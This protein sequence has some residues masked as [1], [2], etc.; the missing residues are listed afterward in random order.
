MIRIDGQQLST[1]Q[2]AAAVAGP[3]SVEVS[4]QA[5]DRVAR[6]H[7]QAVLAGRLR[8]IY[9]LTTG[10]GANR[11][12]DVE[13]DTAGAQ[14]L[15]RSHATAA[16]M[17]RSAER[18]RAMLLIRLN[19]LCAGGAGL[20][21]AVVR[22]LAD[23]VNADEL[24]VIREFVGI[25]TAELSALAATALALQ[26]RSPGLVFGPHDAL[27]FISSNAA[28]LSDAALAATRLVT[29]ARAALA[30]AALSFAAVRGNAEA[31]AAPVEQATPMPGART[32]CRVMRGLVG[33][34]EPA[35][36]QDPYGLRALPQG[37][38]MLLDA[39]TGLTATIDAFANAPSENP[40][41]LADGAVAHHGGFHAGY[42]ALACDG[43]AIAAVQS[44]QLS[45]NRLTYASEPNHTGLEPFLGDG[46]PGASGVMV[47]EYV[48]AAALGD[49]RA[50]AAPAS[51]QSITLSRGIEDTA[52]FASLAARQLLTAAERYELLVSCELVAAV[53]AVR[54]SG[55]A[56][57]GPQLRAVELCAGLPE[58]AGDRDLTADLEIAQRLVPALAELV[59]ASYQD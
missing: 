6:S 12:V 55:P 36:I 48:A 43:A 30:V 21:P 18:V 42:L 47:V 5:L 59:V 1:A 49:L 25:G 29:G 7:Q 37:H 44:G 23:M 20:R 4:D 9:G 46:T 54:M 38:G 58:A 22:A 28:A 34:P 39:L 8:P 33:A 41:I 24:P 11:T 13:P 50:A 27:P 53:R 35:R 16:G 26:E 14:G 10:V 17:P 32:C 40:V 51:T 45:L 15:L 57:T 3:L 56:L 52:S 31:Y 19:Q 2:I